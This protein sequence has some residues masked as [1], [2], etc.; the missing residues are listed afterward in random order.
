MH[1]MVKLMIGMWRLPL[2]VRIW[3]GWLMAVNMVAPLVF[4][5]HAEARVVLA[6]ALCNVV[7]MAVLTAKAGFTRILG[8][9]H[10]LWIP[11]LGYVWLRLGHHPAGDPVALWLRLLLVFNAI[12]LC[13]DAIDVLRFL[14][15]NRA[16]LVAGL[17]TA[18]PRG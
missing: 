8:L 14:R 1:A 2:A 13:L 5:D 15:G 7:V 3:L 17:C 11:L 16:E 6:T 18:G 10:V 4:L 12:S 9:G